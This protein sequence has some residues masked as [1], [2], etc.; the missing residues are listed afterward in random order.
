MAFSGDQVSYR[1]Q[2]ICISSG[3][4][5][6]DFTGKF[7]SDDDGRLEPTAGPAIPLPDV[8]IGAA[9]TG[10]VDADQRLAG[11]TDRNRHLPQDDAWP[12][13]FLDQRTHE[14]SG[15]RTGRI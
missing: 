15:V 5:L 9:D 7:V 3:P 11:A 4:E 13:G 14:S 1:Q 8:E 12:S 10:E 2:S 6:A